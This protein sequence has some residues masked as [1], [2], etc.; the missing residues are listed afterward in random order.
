[1]GRTMPGPMQGQMKGIT[2]YT[3]G[4]C[5]GN[6]GPGGYGVVL[7]YGQHVKHLSGGFR[8][9]T[10][11][12]MEIMG[13]IAGLEALIAPCSVTLHSDSKYVVDAMTQGWV[14]RWKANGWRRNKKDRAVNVDLWERLLAACTDHDVAFK[15]VKGHAGHADNETCDVL[16]KKAA[17][18]N[19]LPPDNGYEQPPSGSGALNTS[20]F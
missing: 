11:N 20:L 16:A 6:P 12:R 13:A 18:R 4:G 14:Q 3:D 19:D 15:W 2:I 10:N 17:A 1:M 8:L 9:T 7:R 5:L